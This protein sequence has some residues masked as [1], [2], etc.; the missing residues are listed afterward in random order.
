MSG[1]TRS[2]WPVERDALLLKMWRAKPHVTLREMSERLNVSKT[3]CTKRL[4]ALNHPARSRA[5][6]DNSKPTSGKKKIL[7]MR[8]C[9]KCRTMFQPTYEGQ[10]FHPQCKPTESATIFS[11]RLPA[12]KPF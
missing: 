6:K 9:L 8:P 2:T 12:G 11:A 7:S 3:T 1:M 10:W 5:L 4:T